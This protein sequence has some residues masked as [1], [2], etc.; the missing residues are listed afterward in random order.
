MRRSENRLSAMVNASSDLIYRISP[1]WK[2]VAVVGGRAADRLPKAPTGSVRRGWTTERIHPDD[3]ARVAEA[4]RRAQ[5][6]L[7]PYEAEHRV[8]IEAGQWSWINSHAVPIRGADGSVSEWFGAATDITQRVRQEEHLRLL[9]NELN[10]RVKNTLAIVQSMV[11]Q[12]LRNCGGN[13]RASEM[14]ESRLQALAAT[15]DVLTRKKWQGATVDEIVRTA[16]AHCLDVAA[17]RFEVQGSDGCLEPRRAVAL[18]MALHEL[19][20]NAMKYGALS[21]PAGHVEIHW[22][23]RG[24]DGN[25]LVLDWRERDGPTVEAPASCGF[26]SRL[27]EKGLPHDLGGRVT[28]AFDPE[29]VHCHIETSLIREQD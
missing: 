23:R 8:E 22:S 17:N 21:T 11:S 27:L 26:G 20:T 10:H 16:I 29:G 2:E 28:L 15:H 12:T 1:D 7:A 9:V 4:I 14:I 6:Q 19:C 24:D 3:R 5:E 25:A 18:S 13:A